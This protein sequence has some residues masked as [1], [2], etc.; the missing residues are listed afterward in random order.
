MVNSVTASS[1][2]NWSYQNTKPCEVLVGDNTQIVPASK[3]VPSETNLSTSSKPKTANSGGNE[4][5]YSRKRRHVSETPHAFVLPN[6]TTNSSDLPSTGGPDSLHA[7]TI[8]PLHDSNNFTSGKLSV[9]DVFAP[10]TN[11]TNTQTLHVETTTVP[12]LE[13]TTQIYEAPENLVAEN[14]GTENFETVLEDTNSSETAGKSDVKNYE[15]I[16]EEDNISDSSL[17]TLDDAVYDEIQ[18]DH[19]TTAIKSESSELQHDSP[20]FSYG[21]DEVQI[22][23]LNHETLSTTQKSK[24]KY[25]TKHIKIES[26]SQ[27]QSKELTDSNL[28][29]LP[30]ENAM[31]LNLKTIRFN[32]PEFLHNTTNSTFSKEFESDDV[33][34]GAKVKVIEVPPIHTP[35]M[36]SSKRVLV[37]VTIATDPDRNNPYSTHSVYVLSLSV[38]TEGNEEPGVNID[39]KEIPKQFRVPVKESDKPLT[40]LPP[41]KLDLD[42]YNDDSGGACECSCPCLDDPNDFSETNSTED[43]DFSVGVTANTTIGHNKSLTTEKSVIDTN[44]EFISNISSL[45]TTMSSESTGS[46][47]IWQTNCPEVTTKL[48]PP[49]T[50]LILEGMAVSQS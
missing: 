49:P 10:P 7:S 41:P 40:T 46:S 8:R 30:V 24:A 5:I 6:A 33:P 36:S 45:S 17:F 1:L 37:N 39:T 13:A 47:E 31:D 22:V 34:H 16:S 21:Q 44:V 3:T 11:N 25:D 20:V 29:V 48:P 19:S 2:L 26:K 50:I 43:Y 27:D 4:F 32:N 28:S 9:L 15:D 14:I 42:R 12:D 23:K 35:S 38:P 18:R